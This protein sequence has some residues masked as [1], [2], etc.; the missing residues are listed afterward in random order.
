[1]IFKP[2]RYHGCYLYV[3]FVYSLVGIHGNIANQLIKVNKNLRVNLTFIILMFSEVQFKLS[4]FL[5]KLTFLAKINLSYWFLIVNFK[6]MI[7]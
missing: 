7:K 6:V 2:C 4:V 3:N 1:M 5:M